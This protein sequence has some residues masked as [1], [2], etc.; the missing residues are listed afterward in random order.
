MSAEAQLKTC[1]R[2][3]AKN[4]TASDDIATCKLECRYQFEDQPAPP[5]SNPPRPATSTVA[6]PPA[7]QPAPRPATATTW[8]AADQT[9]CE[10]LCNNEPVV[11][12]R[13]TCKLNCR[14]KADNNRAAP[15]S[16]TAGTGTY[17]AP[18]SAPTYTPSGRLSANGP[19]VYS[20][21]QPGSAPTPANN[22][23]LQAQVAQCKSECN[24]AS[25]RTATD[26]ATCTLTCDNL[27]D[28]APQG[29]VYHNNSGV[30]GADARRAVIESSAGIAGSPG[31]QSTSQGQW[32]RPAPQ[33]PGATGTTPPA[34]APKGP[35]SVSAATAP[36]AAPATCQAV[37]ACNQGCS[38]AQTTCA[39][40]CDQASRRAT[41]RA[42]CKLT[43][44]S[45]YE[46]CSE[47]CAGKASLCRDKTSK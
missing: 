3:C 15:A 5:A 42:T 17:A 35:T 37:T 39:Q 26:R 40:E 24:R 11:T 4:N 46:V 14:A 22:A 31:P 33:Q 19:M 45:N 6:A 21:S 8:T 38:Y 29:T 43:C 2:Q 28:A 16:P 36:S 30:S 27:L 41:D 32:Y 12:D 7:P 23:A 9:R 34:P 47:D 1:V 25:Y 10:N 13:A 18:S 20:P 44:S